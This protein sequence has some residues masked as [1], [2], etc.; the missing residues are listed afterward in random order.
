LYLRRSAPSAL[1]GS[2]TPARVGFGF[3]RLY[4]A[5]LERPYLWLARVDREDLLNLPYQG[6]AAL[7]RWG[8]G[9][10]SRNQSG[11][12][13]WYATATVLGAA[14]LLGTALL[15]TGDAS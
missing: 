11:I 14:L 13:R 7:T 3:D 6:L 5:L 2:L 15:L 12:L 1:Q 4:T 9:L 10:M 8:H